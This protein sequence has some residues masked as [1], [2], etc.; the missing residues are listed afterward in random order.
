[1]ISSENCRVVIALYKF[2]L[3]LYAVLF[4]DKTFNRTLLRYKYRSEYLLCGRLQWERT[5]VD[6]LNFLTMCLSSLHSLPQDR[7]YGD[8]RH[9]ISFIINICWE[10][11]LRLLQ[12]ENRCITT[13]HKNIKN[14]T[15]EQT[16][17]Y[18]SIRP[19]VSAG[20]GVEFLL[21]HE[22]SP[23]IF[24]HGITT[25]RV[26]KAKLAVP[27]AW[28]KKEN[29]LCKNIL[30]AMNRTED[31]VSAWGRGRISFRQTT[32]PTPFWRPTNRVKAPTANRRH[33]Q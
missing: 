12:T 3:V 8:H 27:S 32:R 24:I 6:S 19:S 13:V 33:A 14:W 28:K 9:I 11:R 5:G 29:H 1:V 20:Y 31:K 23:V 2:D 26:T 16:V 18:T 17:L 7:P 15:L 21:R 25:H 10:F 4:L 30:S 22:N